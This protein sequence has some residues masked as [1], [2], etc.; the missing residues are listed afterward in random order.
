MNTNNQTT[1][2][3]VNTQTEATLPKV[4]PTKAKPAK[5]TKKAKTSAAKG[6]GKPLA[7]VLHESG[8]DSPVA[9]VHKWLAKH[10]KDMR[11]CDALK[12]LD[13]KGIAYYTVR[14][15][16]QVW[17]ADPKASAKKYGTAP[18]VK[19]APADVANLQK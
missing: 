17:F 8:I 16:Y 5:A 6:K 1:T 7:K 10:G 18:K 9:Y 15:Q 11:R 13:A 14:T 19:A 12:A 3:T 2:A 4:A